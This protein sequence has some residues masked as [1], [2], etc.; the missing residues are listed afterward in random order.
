MDF[1]VGNEDRGSARAGAEAFTLIELLVVIVIIA[2]LCGLTIPALTVAKGKGRALECLNNNRQLLFASALYAADNNERFVYNLGGDRQRRLSSLSFK[3]SWVNNV[4]DWELSAGNTN[5][6]FVTQTPFH[7]YLKAAASIYRCPADD[8]LSRVQSRAGWRQR[9][10]SL[11]MNAMVGD[12]GESLQRGVNINNPEY[13]QF[14]KGSDIQDPSGTFVFLDEHPDSINDGYFLNRPDDLEWT[15]LPASYHL[16]AC[17]FGFSDGHA[18]LHK[19]RDPSTRRPNRPDAANLPFAVPAS[20]T[21]D[22]AW[23]TAA[24]SFEP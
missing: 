10:R 22:F 18:G 13:R 7:P 1:A 21:E 20:E 12:P 6:A 3:A 5:L 24:T 23:I 4:M 16:G 17:N 8:V 11:S 19:W 14:L 2:L 9:V 15:D